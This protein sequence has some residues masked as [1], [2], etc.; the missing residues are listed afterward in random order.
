MKTW[1]SV[2]V[3]V[4]VVTLPTLADVFNMGPGLTSLGLVTVGNP[5]NAGELS[6]A[7]AGGFGE[8]R[9]C[10]AVGYTY[11][12]GKYE[13]TAGQYTEFLNAVAATDTYGLYNT[14]MWS[15]GYGCKIQQ[16]GTSGNYTYSIPDANYANRPVD[17]VSW[18]DAARFANWLENGQ[19]TGV[20]GLSTTEDGSYYLNGSNDDSSLIAV[21][22]K[23]SASYVIP[24]ED[25]WYKAAYYDPA[26]PGGAGYWNYPTRSDTHLSN[27]LDPAGINNANFYDYHGIGTGGFCIGGPYWRTPV[28]TFVH[29]PGPYDTF[30]QGGNVW[31][32]N[33]TVIAGS[34]RVLRGGAFNVTDDTLYASFRRIYFPTSEADSLGF[35]IA[36]VGVPSGPGFPFP[37]DFDRDGDVDS[38]DFAHFLA[39]RTGPGNAQSQSQCRDVDLDQ[40]GDVDQE[41]YGLFQ[42]CYSGLGQPADPN[43]AN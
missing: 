22:R 39:C 9:I 31:Q 42:R 14:Y 15:T 7:G 18:G 38:Q 2:V 21:P 4:G 5:G 16:T 1:A 17:Y 30:D 32:W 37:G 12:I 27:L 34:C 23:P 11:N 19:P 26:R 20:Q 13:T 6:G 10:G 36:C 43:C 8:D 40:D 33:E 41:D 28:G 35:R 3:A 25:E 29:S 24:T